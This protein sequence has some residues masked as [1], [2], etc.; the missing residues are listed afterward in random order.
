MN[1][2]GCLRPRIHIFTMAM[3]LKDGDENDNDL[4]SLTKMMTII[5]FVYVVPAVVYS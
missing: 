3:V 2:G 1:S 5:M 4:I